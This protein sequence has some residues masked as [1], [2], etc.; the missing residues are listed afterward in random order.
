[1]EYEKTMITMSRDVSLLLR[2]PVALNSSALTFA[3]HIPGG[4]LSTHFKRLQYLEARLRF[5]E[6]GFSIVIQH[7]LMISFE[8]SE[9]SVR[10]GGNLQG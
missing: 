3:S 5:Y 2:L 1:M 10:G 7:T 6:F 9:A 8:Q 4:A